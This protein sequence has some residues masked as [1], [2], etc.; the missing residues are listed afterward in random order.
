MGRGTRALLALAAVAT[1]GGC[2]C[3]K[4]L[5]EPDQDGKVPDVGLGDKGRDQRLP[6]ARKV[7]DK[8]A[9]SPD[10]GAQPDRDGP[11]ASRDIQIADKPLLIDKRLPDTVTPATVV[12]IAIGPATTCVNV[13]AT[14]QLTATGTFS[15]GS[16]HD[17]TTQAVWSSN[18]VAVATVSNAAGSEG[19]ATGTGVGPGI[20]GQ[21][22]VTASFG[23]KSGSIF[24]SVVEGCKT[25]TDCF[26]Q[27]CCPTPWGCKLCQPPP[28][29]F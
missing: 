28:C 25:D 16:A 15:D 21:A 19:L 7:G 27:A 20:P 1:L 6:D 8:S 3:N 5:L 24:L 17:V 9:A 22:T 12:S 18:N 11:F 26:G 2:S 13:G 23:G 29:L 4:I 14:L 10:R